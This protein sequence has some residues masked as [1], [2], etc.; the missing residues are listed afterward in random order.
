MPFS[1]KATPKR[2]THALLALPITPDSSEIEPNTR[3]MVA[4]D[5]VLDVAVLSVHARVQAR[6]V[7]D[8]FQLLVARL[9]L[10]LED[11]FVALWAR[12]AEVMVV[13]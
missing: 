12:T 8:G 3:A 10:M 13:A 7:R 5:A 1:P 2:S 4:V 11:A 6:Q 9:V